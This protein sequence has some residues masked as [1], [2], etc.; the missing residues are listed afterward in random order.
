MLIKTCCYA[1]LEAQVLL[2]V[3]IRKSGSTG[4]NNNHNDN[5]RAGTSEPDSHVQSGTQVPGPFVKTWQARTEG[6]HAS[7]RARGG[8]GV[9]GGETGNGRG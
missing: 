2:R 4:Q 1:V 6:W 9:K 7:A 5:K 3:D 8:W